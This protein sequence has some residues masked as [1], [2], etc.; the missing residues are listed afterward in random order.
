MNSGYSDPRE[1]QDSYGAY[2]AP[3]EVIDGCPCNY[4]EAECAAM[5]DKRKTGGWC[6][7]PNFIKL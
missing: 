6:R 3:R 7:D 2:Y 1:R 5:I 4:P